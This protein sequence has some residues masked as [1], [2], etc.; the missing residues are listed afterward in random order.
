MN[1][2]E[3]TPL[4]ECKKKACTITLGAA[5]LAIVFSAVIA[6]CLRTIPWQLSLGAKGH[7]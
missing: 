2:I 5:A 4:G 6:G 7:G 3:S 1:G